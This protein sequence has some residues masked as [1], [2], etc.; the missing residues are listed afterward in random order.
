MKIDLKA[1][2]EKDKVR[3]QNL[4]RFYVYE[5]TRYCGSLPG[6]ETPKNGLFECRDLSEYWKNPNHPFVV[7]I[8]GE[9]AGFAL[10]CKKGSTQDV[11]WK[12]G[13]FFITAKYQG[14]GVGKQVACQIF[15]QLPGTWE[16]HQIPENQAAIDFWENVVNSYTNGNFEKSRKVVEHPV[17][18]A[19]IVIK[20]HSKRAQK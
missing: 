16:T 9:L 20:F 6:W 18:K 15:D 2:G 14:K 8:D 3:V 11:D 4:A 7:E 5:M 1:A 13:E 12:I 10:I 17:K 19:M